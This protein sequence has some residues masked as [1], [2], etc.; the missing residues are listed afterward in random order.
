MLWETKT[1]ALGL[2]VMMMGW[3][4]K[5]KCAEM[6]MLKYVVIVVVLNCAVIKL[7][8]YST[9]TTQLYIHVDI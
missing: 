4:D 7:R 9:I 6:R 2:S 3:D 5:L 8:T 1:L